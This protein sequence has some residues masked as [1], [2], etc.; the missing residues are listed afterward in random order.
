MY[1]EGMGTLNVHTIENDNVDQSTL[2][3]TRSGDAGPTW[4]LGRVTVPPSDFDFKV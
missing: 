1:G 4:R 3:W 2:H